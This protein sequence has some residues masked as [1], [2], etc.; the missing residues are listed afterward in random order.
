MFEKR[1]RLKFE[2]VRDNA[3]RFLQ[4]RDVLNPNCRVWIRMIRQ[5]SNYNEWDHYYDFWR[6]YTSD[7][8][9]IYDHNIF[10]WGTLDNYK[11]VLKALNQI[12]Y[13]SPM[14]ITLFLLMEM[15]LYVMLTII[16]NSLLVV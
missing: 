16:I 9:R 8:D 11:S 1:V 10:N 7:V 13:A 3:I 12:Y 14:V 15:F 5:E 4:L 6:K 2:Q